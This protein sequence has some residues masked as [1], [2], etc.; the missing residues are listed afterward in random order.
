MTTQAEN[1][2]ALALVLDHFRTAD[3]EF[4]FIFGQYF[5]GLSGA[6]DNLAADFRTL[7][8]EQTIV[9]L[10]GLAE[11]TRVI[12]YDICMVRFAD[13]PAARMSMN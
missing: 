10:E 8:P 2:H 12:A 1:E 5:A 13:N 6:L 3:P 4:A 11:N 9:R 7:S